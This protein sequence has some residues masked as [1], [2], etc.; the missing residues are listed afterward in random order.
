MIFYFFLALETNNTTISIQPELAPDQL[1]TSN[2]LSIHNELSV[3]ST[4]QNIFNES[5]E[6]QLS[7]KNNTYVSKL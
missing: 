2:L 5:V 1:G 7:S 4:S 3:P 6:K